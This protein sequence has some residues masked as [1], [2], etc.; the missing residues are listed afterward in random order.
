MFRSLREDL[1]LLEQHEHY[2]KRSSR[3]RCTVLTSNGPENLSIPLKKGKN[4]KTNIR[5][6]EISYDEN[7][8]RNHIEAIKS[9]YGSSAFINYYLDD[10]EALLYQESSLLWDLNWAT[11]NWMKKQLGISNEFKLSESFEK[12][13]K[14]EPLM[15]VEANKNQPSKPYA[16]VFEYKFGF[17]DNLSIL[18]LLFCMGPEAKNYI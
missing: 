3:N 16:Q 7:W 11:L 6:V 1:C 18:D 14:E 8:M 5:E 2:Q 13:N 12:I 4:N 17:V 15:R 10:I 9:A